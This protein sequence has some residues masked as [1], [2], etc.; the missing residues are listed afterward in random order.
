[1]QAIGALPL[2]V[3]VQLPE[4]HAILCDCPKAS[5]AARLQVLVVQCAHRFGPLVKLCD[6]SQ[7]PTFPLQRGTRCWQFSRKNHWVVTVPLNQWGW[8]LKFVF[9]LHTQVWSFTWWEVWHKKELI[10]IRCRKGKAEALV[11]LPTL[12]PKQIV[13]IESTLN[14]RSSF[15]LGNVQV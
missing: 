4:W 11:L 8:G 12:P 6:Q 3:V 10:G 13:P 7:A 1:M 5:C 14:Q 15:Q 2:V 9:L